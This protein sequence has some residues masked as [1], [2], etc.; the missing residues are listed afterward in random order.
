MAAAVAAAAT[1]ASQAI[2]VRVSVST[3]GKVDFFKICFMWRDVP[4]MK[5]L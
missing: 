5:A 3:T 1:R 4:K 2:K